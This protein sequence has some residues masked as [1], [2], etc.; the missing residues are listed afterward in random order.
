MDRRTAAVLC[1]YL[2]EENEFLYLIGKDINFKK[3]EKHTPAGDIILDKNEVKEIFEKAIDEEIIFKDRSKERLCRLIKKDAKRIRLIEEPDEEMQMAAIHYGASYIKE[4]KKTTRSVEKEFLLKYSYQAPMLG[5][6]RQDLAE[7][8]NFSAEE[9]AEIVRERPAAMSSVPTELITGDII[10]HFLEGLVK[11]NIPYLYG[12]FSNIP[13]EY[14]D[15][16]YWQSLCMVNGYNY[17]GIPEEKREEYISAKLINYTLEHEESFVGTLWMYEYIP[18]KFKT[19]ELSIRFVRKHFGCLSYLPTNLKND[20][21]YKKLIA[22]EEREGGRLSWFSYIDINSISKELFISTVIKNNIVNI[23]EKTPSSY[24][25]EDVAIIIAENP[26]NDIP[27]KVMTERYFDVMAEKGLVGR[28]P[29]D[30][31]TAERVWKLVKTKKYK[32][33]EKIPDRFKTKDF[34]EKV[35]ENH[36]Y[37]KI[38][39]VKEYLTE[40]I[41]MEAIKNGKITRFDEI[42]KEYQSKKTA[43][44]LAEKGVKWLDIPNE[45]Q[46]ERICELILANYDRTKY[47]WFYCLKKMVFK[48]KEAVDY[49]VLHFKDA[50]E[51]PNLTREQISESLLF[52]P[53]NILKVPEWFLKEDIT[54]ES[55]KDI[56][57]IPNYNECRQLSIFEVLGI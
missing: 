42:P 5:Y 18:E 14:K 40:K 8:K 47:E 32:L 26:N 33:L 1:E 30:K 9:I 34:M 53:M 55:K 2:T 13:K 50:I 7:F 57:N 4:I 12:A 19:E 17:S 27:K 56:K 51:L 16:M 54:E 37:C 15:K 23:P 35:I 29:E 52:Y 44:L 6:M 24:I 22:E 36:L 48:P 41:V 39:D 38:S 43:E 49:A 10:Y 20:N 31:L 21:F 3:L 46:S 28:I 45:F 11:Q 25:N